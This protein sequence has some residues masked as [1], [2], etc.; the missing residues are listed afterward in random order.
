MWISPIKTPCIVQVDFGPWGQNLPGDGEAYCGPT[1][2]VM[3]LYWMSANGFTQVA[4]S[5]YNGRN[6]P[7]ALNLELVVAGLLGTSSETGGGAD[8]VTTYLAACGITV[9]QADNPSSANPDLGWIIEQVAPNV[10]SDPT[11][12]VLAQFSVGW[13]SP[14]KGN[15]SYWQNDGG[16]FLVPVGLTPEGLLLKNA[17]PASLYDVP[18]LP[19]N[20][21]Q[22]VQIVPVPSG[23]TLQ[24]LSLPSQ[25]YT[26]ILSGN[27]GSN[28]SYA[29]LWG[30][31]TWIIPSSARPAIEGYQPATW[32]IDAPQYIYTNGARTGRLPPLV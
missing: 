12:I 3:G 32:T 2:I 20:G 9:T 14:E 21:Q 13:Y 11:S 15:S 31:A 29:V 4:P 8:G 17:Y 18:N 30:A 6:D 26:Q 7:A 16:H 27:K 24:N 22:V 10:A 25:D 1:S 23:L 5:T 28:G 19:E